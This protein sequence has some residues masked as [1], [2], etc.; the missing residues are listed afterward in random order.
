MFVPEIKDI[1]VTYSEK[2]LIKDGKFDSERVNFI[3]D[4]RTLDLQ[5]VPGSGKTTALLAKLTILEKYMPFIN[6]K[7][8]V[9]ISHTNSAVNE[10]KS[11]IGSYCPKLFSYPNFIGTIQSFA[12]TY[13]AKPYMQIVYGITDFHVDDD[14]F[15]K[16]ILSKYHT[17]K[18]S[19]EY[20]K[21]ANLFWGRNI[22]K[23]ES[24]SLLTG[25]CKKSVCERLIEDEVKNLYYDFS[26]EKFY[27][28]GNK[29]CLI[30]DKRNLRYQ[31]LNQIFEETFKKGIISFKYA[32]VFSGKYIELNPSVLE[33]IRK[34]FNFAF[35]D[36]MQDMD[37]LQYELLES[38]FN[39]KDIIYQRVGDSNQSIYNELDNLPNWSDRELILRISGSHRLTP[40][41]A[42]VVSRFSV[43]N[44]MV[45]GLNE[46]SSLK[47]HLI[48]FKSNDRGKVI[49]R[50]LEL[51][52]EYKGDGSIPTTDV[53]HVGVISWVS[54]S[55]DDD[56][57]T[58]SSF[59]DKSDLQCFSRKEKTTLQYE[60]LKLKGMERCEFPDICECIR[61]AMVLVLNNN[62]IEI[63]ERRCTKSN[64]FRFLRLEQ[65]EIY[66]DLNKCIYKWSVQFIS[67]GSEGLVETIKTFIIKM[68]MD[69][70][71]IKLNNLDYLS[72]DEKLVN[73]IEETKSTN[74]NNRCKPQLGTIHS[75]KGQ[76]HTSTLYIESYYDGNYESELLNSIFS[77]DISCYEMILEVEK[78]VGNLL[79][80]I[81]EIEKCGKV[82]GI[83]I[84]K[85]K[86]DKLRRRQLKIENYAKMI[87]V[88]LSRPKHFLCVALEEER[89]KK[90]TVD[91]SIWQVISV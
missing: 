13:F 78:E 66:E 36:E 49:P 22:G 28:K 87:Y 24:I 8:V 15:S 65:P 18:F 42:K 61:N 91:E 21:I 88:G 90:L 4:L 57:L 71:D 46:R 82:R 20:N 52:D 23:A 84:R 72:V 27:I 86:I 32:Y 2:I 54:K 76:T 50:Y 6:G 37:C 62:N 10:W 12:N 75:A 81:E 29:K 30:S 77:G 47:P 70:G 7:G 58:L 79:L 89:Y 31:G 44:D 63:D 34:R 5:S 45:F 74:I 48:H 56:K 55:R 40:Q 1:D 39:N 25:E 35:V 41:L 53:E 51:H 26:D 83:K 16:E 38:C 67:S 59:I 80:E 14:D 73:P 17:I 33:N 64:L 43:S 68:C 60:L 85:G 3:K 69:I 11:K 9:V 19:G